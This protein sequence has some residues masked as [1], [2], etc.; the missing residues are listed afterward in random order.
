MVTKQILIIDDEALQAKALAA[1]V[2]EIFP[3]AT[4][5][6]ASGKE[7]IER[8]I[9]A[10]FYN[11]V[12]L[13]LRM[14]GY[15]FDGISLANRVM[16][17]NP[18][19]KILFVSR[20]TT[21]YMSALAPLLTRGEV[22]GF[23]EKQPYDQWKPELEKFI[24]E[25]YASIESE[26]SKVNAALLSYYAELKNEENIYKKGEKFEN[27]VA[28]LFRSI[29]FKEI[30]K[31][32]RDKSLNETDLIIRNDINDSFLQKFGKYI[33]VECKNKPGE[34]TD[35]NDYIL[36]RAKLE[37]TTCMSELGFLFT[38]S[39]V[40]RNT[41]IEAVRDSKEN[42]K[43]IIID[44]VVMHQLLNSDDL[45]EGLKKVMDNQVKDN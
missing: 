21:E 14:D 29:G 38:T 9:E 15:D 10:K 26:P 25:Y 18:F 36:F 34:K 42:K 31:R 22:I 40:T 24:S 7:E 30:M 1:T 2:L 16:E 4:L 44:N 3:E 33:L 12:L 27:F 13:D 8:S 39:S 19:A 43:I 41:Y 6:V 37:A 28:I 5:F 32:V 23:S 20:F 17:V 35:K 11:L 45:R